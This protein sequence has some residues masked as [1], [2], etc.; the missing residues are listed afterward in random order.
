M[1]LTRHS[2]PAAAQSPSQQQDTVDCHMQGV[3]LHQIDEG[4]AVIDGEEV[5]LAVGQGLA[6]ALERS[7]VIAGAQPD[8]IRG[9]RLTASYQMVING[10]KAVIIDDDASRRDIAAG[11][12]CCQAVI[13]GGDVLCLNHSDDGYPAGHALQTDV[14]ASARRKVHGIPG[15]RINNSWDSRISALRGL[16][17]IKLCQQ[18]SE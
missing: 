13:D 12:A 8:M 14:E 1:L 17:T 2:A 18:P 7:G 16:R 3:T 15:D 10:S 6:H 5:Q 4:A 11:S 9:E